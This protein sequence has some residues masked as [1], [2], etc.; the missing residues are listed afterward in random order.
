LGSAARRRAYGGGRGACSVQ[1]SGRVTQ[2]QETLSRPIPSGSSGLPAG[3]QAD[4]SGRSWRKGLS[5]VLGPQ[6]WSRNTK[7]SGAA[8]NLASQLVPRQA[9]RLHPADSAHLDHEHRA[10]EYYDKLTY[11]PRNAYRP[12]RISP[13]Y[14]MII[15]G[16][17]QRREV[18][19]RSGGADE[20]G[21]GKHPYGSP[22]KKAA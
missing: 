3:R 11:D 9:R 8:G 2:A 15:R 4:L 6:S 18:G 1:I 20:P 7:K 5:E 14:T 19:S 17:E 22:G 13:P 12:S 10:V 16:P 21:A